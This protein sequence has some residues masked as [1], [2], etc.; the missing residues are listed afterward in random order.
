MSS[1]T[2]TLSEAEQSLLRDVKAWLLLSA[3]HDVSP[4]RREMAVIMAERL[5]AGQPL[6]TLAAPQARD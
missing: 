4:A 3:G 6:Q 5:A 2:L 1:P